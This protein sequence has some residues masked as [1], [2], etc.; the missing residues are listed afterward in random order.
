MRKILIPTFFSNYGGSN[1]VLLK[2]AEILKTKYKVIVKAPL[3]E[4]VIQN[5]AIPPTVKRKEQFK[6]VFKF[7]KHFIKEFFWIK[8]EKFDIVYVHDYAAFYI[9]GLIAKLLN[10]KVMWHVH[11]GDV[12]KIERKINFLLS[13]K[14]IYI[15]KFQIP[16]FDKN[17][18]YI[19][20]FVEKFNLN[21]KRGYQNIVIA[22]SICDNK[23]QT[24]G[25]EVVNK[26]KDKKLFLYGTILEKDYFNQ[27]KIDNKKVFY[28]GFEDK[29]EIL[30]F[31]DII[32][33]PS[34]MESQG[35]IFLESLANKIPVLVPDIKAVKEIAKMIGY[36]KYLYKSGNIQ[37]CINKLKLL[38]K[39]SDEEL[40][41]IQK[42][43]LENFS[44]Q[45]F[46]KKL[47]KC[48][49]DV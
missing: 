13:D 18:C 5:F 41:N 32:F 30:K 15:A 39:L 2:S 36:E 6:L 28:K 21:K 14:R 34:K 3:K 48:F 17:Y 25:I 49:S 43:V 45:T 29:M 44:L 1:F 42:K 33:M 24:F 8:K 47:L 7:L 11:D 10:I 31:A 35:L 12:I 9:Y 20:N 40:K 27:L 19:P 38:E 46:E 23:N 16:D 4:A 37:D 26:L 22:G